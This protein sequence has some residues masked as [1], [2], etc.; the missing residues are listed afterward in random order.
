MGLGRLSEALLSKSYTVA[1]LYLST[2]AAEKMKEAEVVSEKEKKKK[3][4]GGEETQ[5][6]LGGGP[7]RAEKRQ[8]VTCRLRGHPHPVEAALSHT[9]VFTQ[10]RGLWMELKGEKVQNA[11]RKVGSPVGVGSRGKQ[12]SWSHESQPCK[13]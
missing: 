3:V 7:P 10:K 1:L 13:D 6:E 8:G 2:A 4:G 5:R 9:R 11:R 12:G